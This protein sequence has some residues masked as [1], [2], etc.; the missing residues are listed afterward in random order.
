MTGTLHG[1][2]FTYMIMSRRI[3]LRIRSVSD[4]VCSGYQNTFYVQ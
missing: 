1:D 4:K 2:V 3:L